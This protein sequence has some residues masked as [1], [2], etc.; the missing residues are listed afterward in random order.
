MNNSMDNDGIITAADVMSKL[1]GEGF[2]TQAASANK[3]VNA[4]RKT[5]KKI[6]GTGEQLAAHTDVVDYRNEVLIIETD[7]SAWSQLL[8]LHS[9][10]IL[11]GLSFALPDIKIKS[12]LFRLK[13]Q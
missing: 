3:I 10:F 2:A 12:L 6:R 9:D 1:F 8:Q 7:H 11:K 13:K 4:W 5:L